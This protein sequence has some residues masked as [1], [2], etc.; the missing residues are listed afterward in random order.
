MSALTHS[1]GD[2]FA[3]LVSAIDAD[4]DENDGVPERRVGSS[5]GD[6]SLVHPERV[7]SVL[8]PSGSFSIAP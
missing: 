2:P 3:R 8:L 1:H 5:Y 7:N 4:E 6:S